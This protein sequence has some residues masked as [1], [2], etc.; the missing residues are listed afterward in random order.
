MTF[1]ACV[2]DQ[3]F[4]DEKFPTHVAQIAK[5]P[6]VWRFRAQACWGIALGYADMKMQRY[7]T[8]EEVFEEFGD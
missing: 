8:R 7:Y 4:E 3:W 2:L 6:R 1:R 5:V